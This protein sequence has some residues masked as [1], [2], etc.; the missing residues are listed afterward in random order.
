MKHDGPTWSYSTIVED[1][2]SPARRRFIAGYDAHFATWKS[3][4]VGETPI[5]S[6]EGA[7]DLQLVKNWVDES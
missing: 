1:S 6:Q 2:K 5:Q 3:A 4:S 7:R